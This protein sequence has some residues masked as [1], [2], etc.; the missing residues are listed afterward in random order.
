MASFLARVRVTLGF[1]VGAIVFWLAQPTRDTIAIGATIAILGESLR[2]WAAGHLH[3]SR[4][5]STSG[6]YS[7]VAHPL[8]LGSSVM[9]IG[10]AVASGRAITA[11]LIATYLAVTL[12]AATKT[13]EAFLRR[14]FGASYDRYRRMDRAAVS[15]ASVRRFSVMQVVANREHHAVLGLAIAVLLLFLKATYNVTF[16]R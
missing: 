10:L 16:R 9:G 2:I 5:V 7:W 1:F 15:S 14:T 4:E 3:K 6:P 11:A 8:Y 12:S 13:E